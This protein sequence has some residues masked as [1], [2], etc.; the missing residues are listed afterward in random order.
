MSQV[1]SKA[2]SPHT[3]GEPP[4]PRALAV[5]REL[6]VRLRPDKVA[7]P[8][9]EGVDI[10]NFNLVVVMD[11]FDQEALLREVAVFDALNPGGCYCARVRRLGEWAPPARAS[12]SASALDRARSLRGDVV[13]PLYGNLGGEA[14]TAAIW[15]AVRV[16]RA[17]CRGLLRELMALA[18]EAG[19]LCE[20]EPA[21]AGDAQQEAHAHDAPH[22]PQLKM[23]AFPPAGGAVAA[24][25]AAVEASLHCPLWGAAFDE[26]A[27]SAAQYGGPSDSADAQRAVWQRRA[28]RGSDGARVAAARVRC[29]GLRVLSAARLTAPPAPGDIRAAPRVDGGR[30][31]VH[32]AL[33]APRAQR[34]QRRRRWL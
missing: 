29:A 14:E 30:H 16:I 21:L 12:A 11:R 15:A 10:V 17:G 18:L 20:E 31:A 7:V 27:G 28:A 34:L 19:V 1:D 6:G 33:H 4:H 26:D 2:L 3:A 13:D 5:A 8:F 24:L 22:A 25:A 23:C 32:R 9:D